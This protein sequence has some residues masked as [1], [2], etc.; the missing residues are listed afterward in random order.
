MGINSQFHLTSTL[1]LLLQ[2]AK[3]IL[4]YAK[5]TAAQVLTDEGLAICGSVLLEY[6]KYC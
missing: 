2:K 4:Y 3:W 6:A 1:H 5:I